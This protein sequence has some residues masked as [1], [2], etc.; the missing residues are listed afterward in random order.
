MNKKYFN[1][2]MKNAPPDPEHSYIF[3]VDNPELAFCIMA[4]GYLATALVE[5]D[6]DYYGVDGFRCYMNDL[7]LSGSHQS[8]YTYVPACSTAK[9]NAELKELVTSCGLKYREGWKLFKEKEHLTEMEYAFELRSILSGFIS[10]FENPVQYSKELERFH[11]V[12]QEGKP[13]K[14]R[15]MSIVEYILDTVPFVVVGITPYVYKTGRYVQDKEGVFLKAEIQKLIYKELISAPNISRVY[16]LLIMQ[17]TVQRSFSS[18]YNF[19]NHWINF[20]NGFYDPIKDEMIP[21]SPEYLSINQIPHEFHKE[22][23]MKILE[24]GFAI[25]AYLSYSIPDAEEQRMLW[26][27]LGYCMTMDM[28]MQKFLMLLGNGG[29]GK[30]VLINLFQKIIG[31]ENTANISPQDLNKRFYATC[32]FGKQLNACGDI[33]CRAMDSTD[34]IKKATG[35]DTLIFE[36][37]GQDAMQFVSHAKLLFSANDMPENL[38]EKSDA[39]YR[40][41][42]ILDM[43]MVIPKEKRDPM[44]KAKME[45]EIEY[46]IHMAVDALKDLYENGG[47]TESEHSRDMVEKIQSDSDSVKAFLDE[48]IC[49]KKSSKICKPDMYEYYLEYCREADRKPLGKKKF[50]NVMERKGFY[51]QKTNGAFCF[52]DVGEKEEGFQE[53]TDSSECPFR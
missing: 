17:Q 5:N 33:P 39:F 2:C 38:E 21:H 34:V 20:K 8:D 37:K 46:A 52:M 44:L 41:L 15:D 45:Q 6:D 16:S 48:R 28:Q 1:Q 12:N 25:K 40:R 7:Y 13:V 47:F 11:C 26:E 32:L 4:Q 9:K 50:Y 30:S 14:I 23:K 3:L 51:T 27:Y 18:F 49:E 36:R 29:T 42:L 31:T 35:E 22:E 10:H 19:P 43:N 53:M 24:G